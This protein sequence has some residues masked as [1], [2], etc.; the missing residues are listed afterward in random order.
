MTRKFELRL[1][2]CDKYILSM[3]RVIPSIPNLKGGKNTYRLL[4]YYR[5]CPTKVKNIYT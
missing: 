5:P 4:I 1:C 3:H 2:V